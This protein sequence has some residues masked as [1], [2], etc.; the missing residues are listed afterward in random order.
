MIFIESFSNKTNRIE[1]SE[2]VKTNVKLTKLCNNGP[3]RMTVWSL[4]AK[5]SANDDITAKKTNY[6]TYDA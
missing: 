3:S 6:D 5:L 2:L 4:P 1:A